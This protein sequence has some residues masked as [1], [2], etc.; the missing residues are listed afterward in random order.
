MHMLTCELTHSRLNHT[1]TEPMIPVRSPKSLLASCTNAGSITLSS[2]ALT[3]D[4][5]QHTM[6][7]EKSS[8]PLYA[9]LRT[10]MCA[11]LSPEFVP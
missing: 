8:S 9:A 5:E 7:G 6:S 11:S 1:V 2:G 10:I 4:T 3:R